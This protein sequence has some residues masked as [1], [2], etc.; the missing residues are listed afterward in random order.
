MEDSPS[1]LQVQHS[2]PMSGNGGKDSTDSRTGRIGAS[3]RGQVT[4]FITYP[5]EAEVVHEIE[6]AVRDATAFGNVNANIT[7][8][9]NIKHGMTHEKLKNMGKMKANI[10]LRQ[11]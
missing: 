4:N 11:L 3:D 10:L 9:I 1:R 8:R 7:R 6:R 5:D 2:F